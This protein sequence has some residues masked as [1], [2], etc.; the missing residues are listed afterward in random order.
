MWRYLAPTANRRGGQPGLRVCPAATL[1]IAHRPG[2]RREHATLLTVR[3][4]NPSA[5]PS[6]R[7][8]GAG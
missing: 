1:T 6:G 7:A 5:R 2:S 8:A 3:V 4:L